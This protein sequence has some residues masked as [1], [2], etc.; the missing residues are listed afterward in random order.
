MKYK[1][2]HINIISYYNERVNSRESNFSKRKICKSSRNIFSLLVC[3]IL[4]I[5]R[6]FLFT[7]RKLR[8]LGNLRY[9][10]PLRMRNSVNRRRAVRSDHCQ[11]SSC[12]P[13]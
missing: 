7:Y 2:Y 5:L 10:R 3:K 4:S 8:T 6:N 1:K 9:F 12:D 13:R 11:P